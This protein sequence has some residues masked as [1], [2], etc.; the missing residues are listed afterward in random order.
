M[1]AY[2]TIGR[3]RN[4]SKKSSDERIYLYKFYIYF[5]NKYQPQFFF[6]KM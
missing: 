4:A 2:S 5:L 6:L 3:A 1:S